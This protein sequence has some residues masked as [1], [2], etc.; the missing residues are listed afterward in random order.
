RLRARPGPVGLV[1]D[2][3]ATSEPSNADGDAG[4]VLLASR[5]T[6]VLCSFPGSQRQPAK[7]DGPM[8]PLQHDRSRRSLI[9][10]ESAPRDPG[11]GLAVNDSL[12]VEDDGQDAA[13]KHDI[14]RLPLARSFRRIDAG[15][16]KAVDAADL[17]AVGFIAVVVLDLD[18][19]AAAQVNA[20]VTPF[21]IAA[22]RFHR[23]FAALT[24]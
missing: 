8:I 4:S 15:G 7:G 11:D 1:G 6:R 16:Q 21:R 17:V 23:A 12:A 10:I 13:D 24:P 18:L 14:K 3:G 22:C 9:A 5:L 20:A 19:V 2:V